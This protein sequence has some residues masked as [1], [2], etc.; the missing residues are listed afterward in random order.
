MA[1]RLTALLNVERGTEPQRLVLEFLKDCIW[2]RYYLSKRYELYRGTHLVA[3]CGSS[4]TLSGSPE[5]QTELKAA[6]ELW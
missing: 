6:M 4:A 3:A 1:R 5:A 2:A